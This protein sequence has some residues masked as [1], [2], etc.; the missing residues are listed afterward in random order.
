MFVLT[1]ITMTCSYKY[2]SGY[3]FTAL[4]ILQG[5]W[6]IRLASGKIE[7]YKRHCYYSGAYY[8]VAYYIFI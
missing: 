3:T 1:I 6:N 7:S 4:L 5:G 2:D 8:Y